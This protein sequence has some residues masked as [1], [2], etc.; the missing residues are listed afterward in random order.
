MGAA[1]GFLLLGQRLSIRDLLAIGLVTVASAGA[2][3]TSRHV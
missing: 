2:T 1:A 3:L